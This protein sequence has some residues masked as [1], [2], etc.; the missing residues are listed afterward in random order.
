MFYLVPAFL[1]SLVSKSCV[2]SLPE[3]LRLGEEMCS[4]TPSKGNS[5]GASCWH[6]VGA[7]QILDVMNSDGA[8]DGAAAASPAEDVWQM[9][10]CRVAT[11]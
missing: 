10:R 3:R 9:L 8:F 4:Y 2:F 1:P 11:F 7:H 5:S 6:I